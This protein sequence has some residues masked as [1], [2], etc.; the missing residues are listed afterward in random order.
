MT[1]F[2]TLTMLAKFQLLNK[3]N[4]TF[5]TSSSRFQAGSKSQILQEVCRLLQTKFMDHTAEGLVSTGEEKS[6]QNPPTWPRYRRT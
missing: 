5:A 4:E 1:I 2:P 3:D 6:G